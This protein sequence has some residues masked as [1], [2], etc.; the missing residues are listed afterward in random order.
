MIQDSG[1]K[2]RNVLLRIHYI[3]IKIQLSLRIEHHQSTLTK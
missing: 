3:D 1:V 2:K